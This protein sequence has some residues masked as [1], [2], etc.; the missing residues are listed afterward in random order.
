[1]QF[2]IEFSVY[3][4]NMRYSVVPNYMKRAI[5]DLINIFLQKLAN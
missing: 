2:S 3:V 5:I 4:P 1:M